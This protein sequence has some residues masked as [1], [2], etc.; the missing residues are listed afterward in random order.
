MGIFFVFTK[1]LVKGFSKKQV[2]CC[3]KLMYVA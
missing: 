3:I 1:T 2:F